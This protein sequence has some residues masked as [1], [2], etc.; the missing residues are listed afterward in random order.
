[1]RSTK[2]PSWIE[3]PGGPRAAAG[4]A[5]R[6]RPGRRTAALRP[7]RARPTA[8]SRSAST[9]PR[10]LPPRA[11]QTAAA[12]RAARDPQALDGPARPAGASGWPRRCKRR[13]AGGARRLA[14]RRLHRERRAPAAPRERD[15]VLRWKL[16]RL[17][18]FRVDELRV[19]AAE[20]APLPGQEEPRAAAPRLRRRAAAGPDRGRLRARR[21][22]PRPQSPT[23]A[24]RC[25]PP[26]VAPAADDGALTALVLVD[27][28]GYTLVFA[29][30]GE[31]V[32]HRYKGLA[33]A[34]PESARGE[35]RRAATS[36]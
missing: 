18:P 3:P 8:A 17:V 33:A 1:M 2:L 35:L 13:L 4:A 9:A 5:A 21:H 30:G 14:A 11:F 10:R 32:L 36:R 27:E 26:C 12:G 6:L 23:P 22:P 20:V 28:G 25:S 15:E 19:S 34:L 24:C 7:L 16:R 29:R 31:P